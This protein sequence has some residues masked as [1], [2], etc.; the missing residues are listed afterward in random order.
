[1]TPPPAEAVVELTKLAAPR[2][3]ENETSRRAREI[4]RPDA[5]HAIAQ[6]GRA[7]LE[8]GTYIDL[9]ASPPPHSGESAYLM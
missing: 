4:A 9:L 2:G 7:M 8:K 6:I 3:K 5:T 1:M